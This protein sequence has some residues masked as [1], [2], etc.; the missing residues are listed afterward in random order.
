MTLPTRHLLG[1]LTTAMA[2]S[3]GIGDATPY[4]EPPP[5]PR[6]RGGY[7]PIHPRESSPPPPREPTRD[8]LLAIEKRKRKAS[9]RAG[10]AR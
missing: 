6:P 2:L 4:P 10:A 3:S 9:K 8:E 1:L 5:Q 7:A